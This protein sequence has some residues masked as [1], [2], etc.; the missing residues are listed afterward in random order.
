MT[1]K[2]RICSSDSLKKTYYPNIVFNKKTFTYYCCQKC[3]S[4]N[5]FPTPTADDFQLIYGE[6]DHSYLAKQEKISFEQKTKKDYQYFQI[7]CLS[8]AVQDLKAKKIMDYACGNGF[9][10]DY[11]QK[12][13]AEAVGIEFDKDF[14]ALLRQKTALNILSKEE[15]E[16]E[17]EN[18]LFDIIHIDHILEHLPNPTELLGFLK[19]YATAR[20]LFLIDGPLDKNACVPRWLIDLFS[21]I[22]R[23]KEKYIAPQHL[24]LTNRKS[25]RLFLEQNGLQIQSFYIKEQA[26]PLPAA[27]SKSLKNN[28]LYLFARFSI[29][30]SAIIPAW[31]NIFHAKANLK[32]FDTIN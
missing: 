9:Y 8:K 27:F 24:S 13:G 17:Y 25:Q 19:T 12:N 7:K 15:F 20:T 29:F 14:A 32:H 4:Y 18:H 11:A 30:F 3:K 1:E 21:R 2:C 31:G 6:N 16:A 23:R 22:R 10:M 28:L 5:L 26:F